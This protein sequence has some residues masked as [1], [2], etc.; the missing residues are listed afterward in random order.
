MYVPKSV[1]KD[2]N[3]IPLPWRERIKR[4]IDFLNSDPYFGSP[5]TGRYQEQRRIRIW[6]YR[7]VYRIDQKQ[8]QVFIIEVK[9]R[10]SVSYG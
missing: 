6:P 7:I 1:K 9:H 8:E 10:G 3:Q 2:L 5:L 4:A